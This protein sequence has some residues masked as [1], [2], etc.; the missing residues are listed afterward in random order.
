MSAIMPAYLMRMPRAL[1]DGDPCPTAARLNLRC[2]QTKGGIED[3][4]LLDRPAVLTLREGPQE[5]HAVLVALD[6][7]RATLS[8][9]GV[10]PVE[11]GLAFRFG[12]R[13]RMIPPQNSATRYRILIEKSSNPFI[14]MKNRTGMNV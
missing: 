3:L 2:L 12:S 14:R 4:R 7:D 8:V 9:S 6:D 11:S 10:R 13:K 5:R 1:A